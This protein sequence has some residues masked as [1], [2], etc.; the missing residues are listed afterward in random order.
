MLYKGADLIR[1]VEW[2]IFD[3]VHYI[4]DVDVSIKTVQHLNN[5]TS[6]HYFSKQMIKY[7]FKNSLK[8]LHWASFSVELSG[9]K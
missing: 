8:E 3:E 4:N 6:S 2:V 5:I 9:K 7:N 1:D